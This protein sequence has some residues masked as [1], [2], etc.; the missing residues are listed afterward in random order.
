MNELW[1]VSFNVQSK[2][3]DM[4]GESIFVCQKWINSNLSERGAGH[5]IL[6]GWEVLS[7]HYSTQSASPSNCR[8]QI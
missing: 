4:R 6:G 2:K 7:V 8:I 3:N 1:A 5:R